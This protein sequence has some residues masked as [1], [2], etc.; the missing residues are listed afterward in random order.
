MAAP[1][2]LLAWRR[3]IKA[4]QYLGVTPWDLARQPSLWVTMAE[5]NSEVDAA[6]QR[7]HESQQTT[8][9]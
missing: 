3:V 5:L 2:D 6:E 8:G 7:W 1:S 9:G 4:A